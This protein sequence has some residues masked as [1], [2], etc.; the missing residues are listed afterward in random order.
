MFRWPIVG[1]LAK[2]AAVSVVLRCCLIHGAFGRS[3]CGAFR[4]FRG[5]DDWFMIAR[6]APRD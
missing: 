1:H 4:P 3:P 2:A 6:L 5:T